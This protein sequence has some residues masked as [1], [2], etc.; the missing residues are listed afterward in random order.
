METAIHHAEFRLAFQ[1]ETNA[2]F[3]QLRA[4]T[5]FWQ[6]ADFCPALLGP[7]QLEMSRA[8]PGDRPSH[9]YA[10]P[11]GRQGAVFG[12]IGREFVHNEGQ[13]KGCLRFEHNRRPV[14][15]RVGTIIRKV[16]R[17]LAHH[18]LPQGRLGPAASGQQIVGLPESVETADQVMLGLAVR[19]SSLGNR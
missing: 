5:A 10:T 8:A 2:A 4:E 6:I 18:E 12:C 16:R 11:G 15:P 19:Q 13:K 1:F 14:H 7:C 17:E 9:V 3:D